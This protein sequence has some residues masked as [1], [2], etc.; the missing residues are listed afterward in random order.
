MAHISSGQM[1]SWA[2]DTGFRNPAVHTI[3]KV[4]VSRRGAYGLMVNWSWIRDI[5]NQIT[6]RIVAFVH[7]AQLVTSKQRFR[8]CDL[9]TQCDDILLNKKIPHAYTRIYI[10]MQIFPSPRLLL[11]LR[12][13]LRGDG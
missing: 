12:A 10:L 2:T 3:S 8:D 5:G 11:R 7:F 1:E 9:H 4:G 13:L 6:H